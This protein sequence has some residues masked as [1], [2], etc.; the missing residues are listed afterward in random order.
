MRRITTTLALA[1]CLLGCGSVPPPSPPS[2]E[3]VELATYDHGCDDQAAEGLLLPHRRHGT[4]ISVVADD[5]PSGTDMRGVVPV[6]WPKGFTGVRLSG[7]D[8]AVLDAAGNVVA[9][10]GR[11]YRLKGMW[12]IGAIGFEPDAPKHVAGFRACGASAL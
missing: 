7:G 5:W 4:D 11:N 8:V 3:P 10:T 1:L 9:T 6:Q 2:G 12:M